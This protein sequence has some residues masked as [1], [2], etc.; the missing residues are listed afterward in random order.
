LTLGTARGMGLPLPQIPSNGYSSPLLIVVLYV[1]WMLAFILLLNEKLPHN[2]L[3][4]S[5][6]I[7]KYFYC[8]V[9]VYEVQETLI[10]LTLHCQI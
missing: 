9:E 2:F 5:H 1:I 10:I 6:S 7:E 8:L 3:S 4:L